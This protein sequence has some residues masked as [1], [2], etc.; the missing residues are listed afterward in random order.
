MRSIRALIGTECAERIQVTNRWKAW[1]DEDGAA[2][3][4]SV[5]HAA[6][7]IA[8]SFGFEFSFL[9]PVVIAG[10]TWTR[11]NRRTCRQP[12]PGPSSRRS[13]NYLPDIGLAEA[14]VQHGSEGEHVQGIGSRLARW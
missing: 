8:R 9:G 7:V 5:N 4:K 10:S 14:A 1:L 2:A 6:T 12:R 3:G 11:R 13:G